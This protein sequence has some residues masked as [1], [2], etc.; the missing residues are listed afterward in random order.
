M[1]KPPVFDPNGY[2]VF[3]KKRRGGIKL[4]RAEIR[5]IKDGRKRLRR[6]M[7][8]RKVYT[9]HEFEVTASSLGLYFDKGRF[10]VLWLWLWHRGA[11]AALLGAAG[12]VMG[13]MYAYSTVTELRGHFTIN[14]SDNLIDQG[15]ELSNT[16]DFA[17]P[18]ARI[19]GTPVEDAPCISIVDLP[20]D[21][22]NVDGSHNGSNYFAHTFYLAKRGEGEADYEFSLSVN[23]ESQNASKAIWLMLFEDGVPTIYAKA[24]GQTGEAEH[25]PSLGNDRFGY[26]EPL[27]AESQFS[28]ITERAGRTYYRLTPRSFVSDRLV[29]E[30]IQENVAQDEVHKYTVVIWLEGDD[31]DCTNDLIGAHIGLQMDFHLLER[32]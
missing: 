16:V 29:T 3:F 17:N 1:S 6:E 7:R 19:Y 24:S 9:R 27:F 25:I 4:T 21:V 15:F 14:L 18:T 20:S 26:K 11:L 13:G 5:E 31:P 23:S 12:L 32:S 8:E 30:S 10:L 22:D 2:P 28:V